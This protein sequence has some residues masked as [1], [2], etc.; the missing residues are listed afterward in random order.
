MEILCGLNDVTHHD[1][2]HLLWITLW[3]D[4]TLD[5]LTGSTCFTTLDLT[6]GYRQVEFTLE[7][8]EERGALNSMSCSL[9]LPKLWPHFK[10]LWN[11]HILILDYRVC[12]V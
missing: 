7:H 3:I 8:K 4:L 12:I 1:A 9:P 2:Y 11:V 6:F 10:T 5:S